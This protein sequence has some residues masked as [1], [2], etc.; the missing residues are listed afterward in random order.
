[1]DPQRTDRLQNLHPNGHLLTSQYPSVRSRRLQKLPGDPHTTTPEQAPDLHITGIS[2]SKLRHQ[3]LGN[4]TWQ[5]TSI[6]HSGV[7]NVPWAQTSG[8]RLKPVPVNH[9]PVICSYSKP[10]NITLHGHP[11]IASSSQAQHFVRQFGRTLA[12]AESQSWW[13]YRFAAYTVLSRNPGI[14]Q[15]GASQ[16]IAAPQPPRH[17]L[18]QRP[19]V[20][21][22][23]NPYNLWTKPVLMHATYSHPESTRHLQEGRAQMS[24]S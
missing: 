3:S 19:E 17:S 4:H 2:V 10:L 12:P 18:L 24:P 7:S 22:R 21:A 1:M 6:A 13:N 14:L 11:L 8:W 9:N 20:A 23:S 15:K 5:K 16:R